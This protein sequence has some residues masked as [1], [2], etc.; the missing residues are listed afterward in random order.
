MVTENKEVPFFARYLEGQEFPRVKTGVK[1]GIGGG[2]VTLKYPSD[3][4]EIAFTLKYPSD[5]DET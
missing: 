5:K 1:S 3:S 2:F 4:D